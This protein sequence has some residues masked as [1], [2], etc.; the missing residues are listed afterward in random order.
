MKR[1]RSPLAPHP[2]RAHSLSSS[3]LAVT[4]FSAGFGWECRLPRPLTTTGVHHRFY[5]GEA[6][7][8]V[9]C[10]GLTTLLC[11][12]A[13]RELV[14]PRGVLTAA[15]RAAVTKCCAAATV[16]ALTPGAEFPPPQE[17]WAAL[18]G[19]F[20]VT[21][22]AAGSPAVLPAVAGATDAA[23]AALA[24]LVGH[25]RR[26]KVDAELT[27]AA[28]VCGHAQYEGAMRLDG[29]TIR[30]L[31]L[32]ENSEG[33]TAGT[34]L[35]PAPPSLPL[36]LSLALRSPVV[37]RTVGFSF[38]TPERYVPLCSQSCISL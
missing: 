8:D 13:P 29:A 11:H 23:R 33:G 16:S 31:E 22:A 20:G 6:E 32:L 5:L 28:E 18:N 26:L 12:V 15:A 7:D 14:V 25:L 1:T 34:L 17:A 4:Q 19:T 9:A 10:T 3:S 2:S 30:N 35:V 24:A 37:Y 36:S 38:R 21:T 27:A